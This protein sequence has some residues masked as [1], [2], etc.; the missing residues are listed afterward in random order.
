MKWFE[1]AAVTT[2]IVKS[3]RK[4]SVFNTSPGRQSSGHLALSMFVSRPVRP[5]FMAIWQYCQRIMRF[6]CAIT[7]EH[8]SQSS[9]WKRSKPL[10]GSH[11]IES[12]SIFA[13]L[14]GWHLESATEMFRHETACF[15]ELFALASTTYGIIRH[16]KTS[17]NLARERWDSQVLHV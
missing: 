16:P 7:V 13:F 15:Y 9:L 17:E 12:E 8:K 11:H 4:H 5:N 1:R 10:R 6:Y 14:W 2:F 3:L